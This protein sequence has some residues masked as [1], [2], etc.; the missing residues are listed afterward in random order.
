MPVLPDPRHEKFAQ[1][2]AS[3]LSTVDAYAA[4]GFQR[5]TSNAARLIANDRVRARVVELLEKTAAESI[6]TETA[7]QRV[8][9]L[10]YEKLAQALPSIPITSAADARALA[11]IALNLDKDRRVEDGGVSDRQGGEKSGKLA[12]ELEAVRE[13]LRAAKDAMRAAPTAESELAAEVDEDAPSLAAPIR[14]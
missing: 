14:H 2:L 1:L 12:E 5:H 11:D 6:A 8:I 13:W 3:G 9:R 10:A 7:K 4:A